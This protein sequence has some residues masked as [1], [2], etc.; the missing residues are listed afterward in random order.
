MHFLGLAGMPRR[1]PSY[2]EAYSDWNVIATVGSCISVLSLVFFFIIIFKLFV[3]GKPL[4]K[5]QR[6]KNYKLNQLNNKDTN[7]Y[8]AYCENYYKALYS[9][10]IERKLSI[11]ILRAFNN[12]STKDTIAHFIVAHSAFSSSNFLSKLFNKML[13][14]SLYDNLPLNGE[15]KGTSLA[16]RHS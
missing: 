8:T 6:G 9:N 7:I 4:S 1:I 10:Y 3:D 11:F 15:E 13:S 16:T 2:P 14:E 5:G 12:E